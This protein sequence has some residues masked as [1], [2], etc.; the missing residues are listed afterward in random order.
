MRLGDNLARALAH[1]RTHRARHSV[2]S[3][4]LQKTRP[5]HSEKGFRRWTLSSPLAQTGLPAPPIEDDQKASHRGY[6]A[7]STI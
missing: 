5:P 4:S 1:L 6:R 7:R 2:L 3:T